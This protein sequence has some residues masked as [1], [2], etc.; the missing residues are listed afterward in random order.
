MIGLPRQG[1]RQPVRH[2]AIVG[3]LDKEVS[4]SETASGRIFRLDEISEK[5]VAPL[6]F[7]LAGHPSFEHVVVLKLAHKVLSLR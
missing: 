5:D 6:S 7:D 1:G 2:R 4:Q 3:R